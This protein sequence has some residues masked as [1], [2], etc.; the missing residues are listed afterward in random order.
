METK[1]GSVIEGDGSSW[2]TCCSEE[3]HKCV[4]NP[5]MQYIADVLLDTHICPHSWHET[6]MAANE[7]PKL[8][9]HFEESKAYKHRVM[10]YIFCINAIRRSGHRGTSSLNWWMNFVLWI[11]A[12]TDAPEIFLNGESTKFKDMHGVERWWRGV[13]EGDDSFCRLVPGIKEGDSF[14]TEFLER[15]KRYGHRMKLVI[16]TIQGESC[17]THYEIKNRK[18]TG[19]FTPD[20]GRSLT[21]WGISCS[22]GSLEAFKRG[23][24][25]KIRETAAAAALSR[26]YDFAGILPSLSRKFQRYYIHPDCVVDWHI[27]DLYGHTLCTGFFRSNLCTHAPVLGVHCWTSKE[28]QLGCHPRSGSS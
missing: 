5:V 13:F 2:D 15:W 19:R 17:G 27:W 20:V 12:I 23:D 16:C 9:L 22:P 3:L 24:A 21:N 26:P 1:E 7:K 25:M 10:E 18:L 28:L 6:H 14:Y 11:C 4:E 8:K